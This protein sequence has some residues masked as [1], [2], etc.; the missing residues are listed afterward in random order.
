MIRTAKNLKKPALIDN[1]YIYSY[2]ASSKDNLNK[3]L[4]KLH[5]IFLKKLFWSSTNN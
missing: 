1:R 2:F 3:N 5:N 4:L